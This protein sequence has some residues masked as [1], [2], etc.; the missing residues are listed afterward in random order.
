[1]NGRKEMNTISTNTSFY[2]PLEP[3]VSGKENIKP[4]TIQTPVK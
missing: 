4:L 1:M 3:R 2:D